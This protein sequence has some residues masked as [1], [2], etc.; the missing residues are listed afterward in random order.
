MFHNNLHRSF[1]AVIFASICLL[2]S[3]SIFKSN[4]ASQKKVPSS[5]E[6][7]ATNSYQ[8]AMLD[9]VNRF[10]EIAMREQTRVGIPSS[11]TLAQGLLESN[12][13]RSDLAQKGNNHFG[14]KCHADWQ[15]QT[16]YLLDDDKDPMTGELV[17]SCFRVYNNPE[18]SYVAHSE[19]LHDPK[20]VNRYGSLFQFSPTD[21]ENWSQGLVRAGYA[22]DPTYGDRL[23]KII[24]DYQLHD[25]DLKTPSGF[26]NGS[27]VASNG[28]YNQNY[29]SGVAPSYPSG[30]TSN[31]P[32]GTTGV[33]T[34]GYNPNYPNNTGVNTNGYNPNYP[35]NAGVN[36]NG[37]TPNL[38]AMGSLNSVKYVRSYG[39]LTLEQIAA[40]ND[41]R[42]ASLIEYND[43]NLNPS[44]PLPEGT[45][46]Y[47][48]RKRSYFSG[49]ESFA[50]V[51]QCQTMFDISQQYGVTLDK[52][53]SRNKMTPG[54][55]PMVGEKISLR[56]G[57]FE[58]IDKPQ[59]RDT[60][61]EWYKCHPINSNYPNSNVA[62]RPTTNN[63]DG[64]NFDISP[65]DPSNPQNTTGYVVP[66]PNGSNV[67]V[68]NDNQPNYNTPPAYPNNNSSYPSSAPTNTYPNNNST[69]PSTNG[70][71]TYPSTSSAPVGTIIYDNPNSGQTNNASS[72]PNATYPNNNSTY[73]NTNGTVT[74]PNTAPTNTYPS[75]S[76]PNTTTRPTYPTTKPTYPA[77]RPT[78]PAPVRPNVPTLVTT[79]AS[80]YIVQPG[81]TLWRIS[82]MFNVSVD[83]L[84]ALNGLPDNNIRI[85]QTL[86]IK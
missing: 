72:Y 70:T 5:Y 37:G 29:P 82:K 7:K 59:L 49:D 79:N 10:K 13:G 61:G 44:V 26:P 58:K 48:Q 77:T 36:T 52:L 20:K 18:E 53:Y 50:R 28:T 74:Y 71:V 25:Y 12:A 17:K 1:A 16:F 80:T 63:G 78:A 39:G 65:K 9:Y 41:V 76:Y 69:Y 86:R 83:Q 22:T 54:D 8:Q 67:S 81:E 42:L 33:N 23:I 38:P 75:N 66:Q 73:P 64:L 32:N 45:I 14:I 3:C 19:F 46:V 55:Q 47:T 56:R 6:I 21:Y 68:T 57:W 24:D 35:S 34:N 85:G 43:N 15:G 30:N 31:Y 62:N 11:V 84:K 4:S 60:T 27:T 51:K 40:R 2:S